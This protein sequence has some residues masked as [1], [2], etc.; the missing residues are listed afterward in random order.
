[1]LAPPG[2][3][4]GGNTGEFGAIFGIGSLISGA[5]VAVTV[6]IKRVLS[7]ASGLYRYIPVLLNPFLI[8]A[9]FIDSSYACLNEAVKFVL[10]MCSLFPVT[11]KSFIASINFESLTFKDLK[12]TNV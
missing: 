1:M 11:L 10:P 6:G 3:L 8:V 7:M 12:K 4:G 5:E 2:I 9:R